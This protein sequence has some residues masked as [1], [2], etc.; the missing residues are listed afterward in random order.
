M[1]K[2]HYSP[3]IVP[4]L[5]VC[6]C[7][8]NYKFWRARKEGMTLHENHCSSCQG[9]GINRSEFKDLF[10]FI[11]ESKEGETWVAVDGSGS[12][13]ETIQAL[14]K[15]LFLRLPY[16]AGI[17]WGD[18]STAKEV[19]EEEKTRVS[20]VRGVQQDWTLWRFVKVCGEED[21]SLLL[22]QKKETL[23][24][25]LQTDGRIRL[26]TDTAYL[27]LSPENLDRAKLI[28]LLEG[29]AIYN[30]TQ[31]LKQQEEIEDEN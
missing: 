10:S 3:A 8:L 14:D 31:T 21:Y 12:W 17:A 26:E 4:L 27:Y 15:G 29:R 24:W 30:K 2:L 5:R 7:C 13:R 25:E 18:F 9:T 22:D 20:R 16:N 19:F 23:F 28:S 11:K 1:S 6:L